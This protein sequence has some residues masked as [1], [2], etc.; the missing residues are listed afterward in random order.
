MGFMSDIKQK[1][2]LDVFSETVV[3]IA[4]NVKKHIGRRLKKINIKRVTKMFSPYTDI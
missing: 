2:I 1:I 4:Y 3:I